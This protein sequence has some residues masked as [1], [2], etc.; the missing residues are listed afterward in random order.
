MDEHGLIL[1]VQ[2]VRPEGC[3]YDSGF[4]LIVPEDIPLPSEYAGNMPA[5]SD[6]FDLLDFDHC[7]NRFGAQLHRYFKT[8][9]SDK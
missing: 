1:G 3:A 7:P 6:L 2:S 9:V 4:N 5:A 8:G